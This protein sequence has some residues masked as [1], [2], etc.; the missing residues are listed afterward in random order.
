[1]DYRHILDY[2]GDLAKQ[3]MTELVLTKKAT[4][5]DSFT[6]L[7][8]FVG[9]IRWQVIN[10]DEI[11]NVKRKIMKHPHWFDQV[12]S[13]TGDLQMW[14]ESEVQISVTN[15]NALIAKAFNPFGMRESSE[16]P[17]LGRILS[18][19]PWLR[20]VFYMSRA[21]LNALLA[22]LVIQARQKK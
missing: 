8:D 16:L 7:V 2:V 21:N 6:E 12:G 5:A 15:Y 4:E 17:E 22:E 3:L 9:N 19:E 20:T 10:L 1:M 13:I 14:M 18:D 11:E